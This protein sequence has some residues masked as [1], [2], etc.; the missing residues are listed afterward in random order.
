MSTRGPHRVQGHRP[1]AKA[2][3]TWLVV[4]PDRDTQI[5]SCEVRSDAERIAALL[6]GTQP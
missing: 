4:H 2:T 5:C 6:N 1:H 3:T